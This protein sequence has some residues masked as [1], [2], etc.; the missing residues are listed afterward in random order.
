MAEGVIYFEHASKAPVTELYD[1]SQEASYM[2]PD[3][4]WLSLPNAWASFNNIPRDS[5]TWF[6]TMAIQ[7]STFEPFPWTNKGACRIVQLDLSD[8]THIDAFIDRYRRDGMQK[9][10]NWCKVANDYGGVSFVGCNGIEKQTSRDFN[11]RDGCWVLS[12]DVDSVCLWNCLAMSTTSTH[13]AKIY[14][15]LNNA[16]LSLIGSQPCE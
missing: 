6:Y 8:R 10:V 11:Q 9:D 16:H 3:G 13:S 5:N 14:V 7:N 12:I 1:V 15:V 2:K 4:L